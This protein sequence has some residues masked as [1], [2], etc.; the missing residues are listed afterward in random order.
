MFAV[1][2]V[3]IILFHFVCCSFE[4]SFF[5]SFIHSSAFFLSFIPL[6]FFF[7]S[8]LCVF[9]FNHS[10]ALY[11]SIILIIVM[12]KIFFYNFF[13]RLLPFMSVLLSFLYQYFMFFL[14]FLFYSASISPTVTIPRIYNSRAYH[15]QSNC[16]G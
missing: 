8:F 14:L 7:P 9:S 10:S 4:R 1:L 3:N 15:S 12:F 2:S 16:F 11:Y 6:R 13:S 5:F